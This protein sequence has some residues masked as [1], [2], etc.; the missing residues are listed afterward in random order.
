MTDI[1]D[2]TATEA[3]AAIAAGRLSPAALMEACLDR[4]AAREPEVRAFAW[5]D[6]ALAR[7]AAAAAK[8]GP[9]GGIPFAVKDVIDTADQPSQYGSPIWA[10]HRPRSDAA[11]VAAARRAGAVIIGK[12]VTTEFATRHP[13][14]TANPRNLKHT[15]GGS[16]SGSAAG[17]AAGFFPLAFG[18]QTAGSIVRPAAYC[19]VVGFKPSYGT[20]HRAGMK[21][22]SESLDTIGVMARSVADCAL[23]MS[24]MTGIDHGNPAAKAPRAPRLALVMGPTADQAAPETLALMERVAE[25]CR[26]AGAEVVPL[27]LPAACAAAVDAHPHVMNM[28][29]AEAIGWEVDHAGAQ[30]S[31]VLAERMGWAR[32]QPVAKLVEGRI[33]FAAARAA[34]ADALAGF[35]AVLTPSAPGEAP[36]GLAWTGDPAFNTLWT[37]LHVPCATVPAGTGPRGLPLGVQVAGRIG[38]DAATL[39]WAG[40]VQS[41][42]G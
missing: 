37:L 8:D 17:V 24:A 15:P 34:Y 13:G 5:L 19:G 18:T 26:R 12:T 2:L 4:V 29:S 1:P 42:L 10:G 33:A 31:P 11:C 23:A 40:W 20:L 38:E 14:P 36:E 35:D 39:A 32:T 22:M 6:P 16:S 30:L 7:R 21:V 27:D 3:R 25:A 28:E 41:A 9:L